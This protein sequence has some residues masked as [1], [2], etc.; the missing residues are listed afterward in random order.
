MAKVDFEA[1]NVASALSLSA[2]YCLAL[3]FIS[4]SPFLTLSPS[5]TGR[6]TI[7]PVTSGVITTLN[8]GSIFPVV[9]TF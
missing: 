6:E 5:L 2:R 4:K 3:I 1:N 8:S 9:D 7:S